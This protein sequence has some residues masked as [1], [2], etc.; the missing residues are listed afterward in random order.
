MHTHRHIH[1]SAGKRSGAVAVSH[2]LGCLKSRHSGSYIAVVGLAY[3]LVFA[4]KL[5]PNRETLAPSSAAGIPRQ[6]L[7]QAVISKPRRSSEKQS[8]RRR[9]PG[10]AKRS[11]IDVVREGERLETPLDTLRFAAGDQLLLETSVARSRNQGNVRRAFPIGSRPR[12]R[13]HRR[14]RSRPD[15]REFSGTAPR[16]LARRFVTSISSSVMA[17]S[18]WPSIAREKTCANISRT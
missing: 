6:F 12:A 5:L 18:F 10:C 14:T 11:I 1:Q 2:H 3:L 7:T 16:F 13:S 15:G 17:S 4:R 8:P 9:W